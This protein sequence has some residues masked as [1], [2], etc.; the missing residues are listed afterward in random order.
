MKTAPM[1]TLLSL[2]QIA[3]L[4]GCGT[5]ARRLPSEPAADRSV[6]TLPRFSAWSEPVSLGPVVNSTFADFDPFISKDG[7]S[8]Y[9]A[10]GRGRGG[11]GQRDLWVSRRASRNAPWGSPKNLGPT[12]NTAVHEVKPTLS[13]DGRRLYF[14]SDRLGGFGAF[15]LYV[16]RRHDTH[17]D[18]G[19]QPPVNL[20]SGI[21]TTANEESAM[22]FFEDDETD[23]TIAY[24][25]SD[26][27][28]GIG[29]EDIYATTLLSNGT[30]GPVTL[31]QELSTPSFD[32]DPAIRRDGLEM[33][34]ASDR[35]GT[36]GADDIWVATRECTADAWSAPVNLGPLVNTPTRPSD[37]EQAND[38]RPSL[39][40]DGTTLYFN[41][42]FRAG[43]L[44]DM[45]D[46]WVTTRTKIQ[47]D[48]RDAV[49]G[50][51]DDEPDHCRDRQH[52]PRP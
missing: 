12:I 5:E 44:S 30:F 33:F 35:P 52:Q 31:V 6:S 45:F 49:D 14:A 20:G 40:S 28:D 3:L 32:H 38:W 16:S 19:W 51:D 4:A 34:L 7:L 21:N 18:F 23:V 1:F 25:V 26:R 17:D 43:N 10:A 46:I 24:F 27:L 15:D 29:E 37:E 22:T 50:D 9:F 8:L 47:H 42:A 48:S 11:F 13:P 39:S 41:S 36:Y 2:A